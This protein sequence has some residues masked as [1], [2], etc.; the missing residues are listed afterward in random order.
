MY[1]L[2]PATKPADL[3][4]GI[5]SFMKLGWETDCL[6]VKMSIEEHGKG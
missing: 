3:A 1:R 6:V 2:A 5:L 4:P